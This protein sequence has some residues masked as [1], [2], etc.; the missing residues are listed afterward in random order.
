M[1]KLSK[2]NF[3][4]SKKLKLYV[5]L[6]LIFILIQLIIINSIKARRTLKKQILE[7]NNFFDNILKVRKLEEN[8]NENIFSTNCDKICS[9]ADEELFEYYKTGNLENIEDFDNYMTYENKDKPY[10]KALINIINYYIFNDTKNEDI[11]SSTNIK[12]DIITYSK[13]V[14]PILIF[15]VIGVLTIPFWLV[16]LICC[17][18]NCCC[19]CCCKKPECK[20]RCFII[21]FVLYMISIAA[22]IYGFIKSDSIV[23]GISNTECSILKFYEQILEGETKQ[24]L[25]KWAGIKKIS[26]ILMNIKDEIKDLRKNELNELNQE[27]DNIRNKKISFKNKMKESGNA[28]F[29]FF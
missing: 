16:C 23:I 25:P 28:F 18:C 4:F 13:H 21:T 29:S 8:Q 5:K 6:I 27:L 11:E 19:C 7:E 26:Q 12:D 24:T 3:I 10:F 1:V 2:E 14:I 15:L 20:F 17:C 9:N 22:C